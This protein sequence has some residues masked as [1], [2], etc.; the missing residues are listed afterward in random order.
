MRLIA[1]GVA[2]AAFSRHSTTNTGALIFDL[3]YS[4][5]VAECEALAIVPLPPEQ[6]LALIG[7]LVERATPTPPRH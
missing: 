6:L 5:Y 1:A 4:R 2:R 7:A 3:F